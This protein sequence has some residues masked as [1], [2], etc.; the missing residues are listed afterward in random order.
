MNPQ[1]VKRNMDLVALVTSFFLDHPDV[2]E[3]V[4]SDFRLIVLPD[5]DRELCQYNL[6][7]LAKQEKQDKPVII[8]RVKTHQADCKKAAPQV[9]VPLA[10]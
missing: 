3:R 6:D 7:L 4:P 8:A 1:I 5:D 2:L 9:Y 10:V